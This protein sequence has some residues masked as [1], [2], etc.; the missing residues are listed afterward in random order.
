MTHHHDHHHDRTDHVITP[1]DIEYNRPWC[2]HRSC[3][4]DDDDRDND[5]T[6]DDDNDDDDDDDGAGDDNCDSHASQCHGQVAMT[7]G[8]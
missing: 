7:T 3:G 8:R 2:R 4:H 1:H 6:D 5:N